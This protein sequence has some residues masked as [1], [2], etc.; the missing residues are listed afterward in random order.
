MSYASLDQRDQNNYWS[1]APPYDSQNDFELKSTAPSI[2]SVNSSFVG[3]GG[4]VRSDSASDYQNL[5]RPIPGDNLGTQWSPGFW[6]QLPILGILSLFGV[7]ASE[8]SL[9]HTENHD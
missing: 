3:Y 9:A 2:S 8:C 4:P 5:L 6:K 7:L 1:A